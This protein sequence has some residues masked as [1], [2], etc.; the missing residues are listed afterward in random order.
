MV[1]QWLQME[2]T[3]KEEKSPVTLCEWVH[4]HDELTF[5]LR[6]EVKEGAVGLSRFLENWVMRKTQLKKLGGKVKAVKAKNL[7]GK[8]WYG[9]VFTYDDDEP[10]NLDPF[11]ILMFGY[12]VTGCV[13]WFAEERVRDKYYMWFSN[14]P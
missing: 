10:M 3:A 6:D 7:F 14:P 12:K 8:E 1:R 2:Q 13:C 11:S 4:N 5:S 9:L